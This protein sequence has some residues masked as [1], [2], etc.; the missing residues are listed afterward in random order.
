MPATPTMKNTSFRIIA[1]VLAVILIISSLFA[2]AGCG[3]EKEPKDPIVAM[4]DNYV[5]A[6]TAE[7]IDAYMD[8]VDKGSAEINID[9][10][11]ASMNRVF[12]EYDI[13]AKVYN[14]EI[15]ERTDTSAIATATIEYINEGDNAYIDNRVTGEYKLSFKNDKWVITG[16]TMKSIEYLDGT[17]ISESDAT[18]TVPDSSASNSDVINSSN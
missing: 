13:S 3:K 17:I 18:Y 2:L 16:S 7:D 11:K 4:F 12:D 1:A 10:I 15:T 6:I 14:L 8:C 9:T 5:A